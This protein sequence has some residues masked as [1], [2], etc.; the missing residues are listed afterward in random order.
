MLAYNCTTIDDHH[1][2]VQKL[3]EQ[4]CFNRLINTS[5]PEVPLHVIAKIAMRD[6]TVRAASLQAFTVAQE[7]SVSLHQ[8]VQVAVRASRSRPRTDNGPAGASG[9]RLPPSR[10]LGHTPPLSP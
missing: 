2:G 4:K 3:R 5:E 10:H 8:F 9:L 1:P 7:V 6:T